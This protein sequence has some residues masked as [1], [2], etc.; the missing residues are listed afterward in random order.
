MTPQLLQAIKLLQLSAVEL[1]QHVE[2]ELTANPLLERPDDTDDGPIAPE[3]GTDTTESRP[4]S[5]GDATDFDDSGTDAVA[6]EGDWASDG[7]QTTQVE[8][9]QQ[10]DTS[11]DNVF[12][13][14]TVAPTATATPEAD[15]PTL[16]GE[17]WSGISAGG[18]FDGEEGPGLESLSEAVPDLRTH[19]ERQLALATAD[20][21]ERMIGRAIIDAI[22]PSGY[23]T[24]NIENIADSLG[25]SAGR[26]EVVLGLVQSFDPS[27]VGARNLAECLAI[28]LRERD[29]LDPAMQAMLSRLDLLGRRDFAALQKICKVDQEDIADMV[30]EI[31][32]LEPKPGRSFGE[33]PATPVIPDVLVRPASSGGWTVELNPDALPRVI[34]SQTYYARVIRSA[35][36]E[37]EKR[38]LTDSW[39]SATRLIRNLDQRAR[40]ILKVASEIVKRQDGFLIE[41]VTKLRPLTLKQVGDT[42]GLHES[43]VSRVTSGKFMATHRGLF[44]LKYFFAAG[45]SAADGGEG[46]SSEAVRHRIRQL[47]EAEEP[48]R[49]LSDD[50]LAE[51]LSRE[52][53][54]VARR[55]VAKYRE[56]LRIAGSKERRREKM[57]LS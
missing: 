43:T 38:F 55:T 30:R 10:L 28:Q 2:A 7:L 42:I 53:I 52:G 51:M 23:L 32:A 40:T 15:G 45:V 4:D 39:Q 16:G 47:I 48:R 12:D 36:G 20:G 1:A 31:R 19:L 17:I 5:D 6:G 56:S 26:A 50:S 18:R 21:G 49:V 14:E 25:V 57:A 37:Q 44:E 13:G 33:A 29:R 35:K 46:T 9:E 54:T 24:D 41:G 27:G 34:A 22:E 11:L 3:G 8:V